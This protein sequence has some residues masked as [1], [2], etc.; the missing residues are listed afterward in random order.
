MCILFPVIDTVQR[1][2]SKVLAPF[3]PPKYEYVISVRMS[4]LQIQL[5]SYYLEHF[6]KSG[7]A[8]QTEKVESS[9]LFSDFQEL[10]RVWTHPKALLLAC[11]RRESKNSSQLNGT[12]RGILAKLGKNSSN[13]DD[14]D[15][16]ELENASYFGKLC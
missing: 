11:R 7:S 12:K 6:T 1:F 15:F 9:R 8:Q 13:N 5:Y 16:A 10:A 4:K 14:A 3:L 2:D